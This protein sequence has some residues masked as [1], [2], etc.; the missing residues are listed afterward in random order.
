MINLTKVLSFKKIIMSFEKQD[1]NLEQE[2]LNNKDKFEK[3]FDSKSNSRFDTKEN[4]IMK[5]IA[6]NY[7]E[8]NI[9]NTLSWALEETVWSHLKW[10]SAPEKAQ[11]EEIKSEFSEQLKWKE[12]PEAILELSE[13]LTELIS[14]VNWTTGWKWKNLQANLDALTKQEQLAN[15]SR[16][17]FAEKMAEFIKKTQERKQQEQIKQTEKAQ[18]ANKAGNEEQKVSA[19]EAVEKL[20]DWPPA[21]NHYTI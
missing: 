6:E 9:V 11:F 2:A 3:K 13:N 16:L 17:E 12:W 4:P 5:V 1:N 15:K 18:K 20:K 10:L 8:K 14:I 7:D 21:D 19:N